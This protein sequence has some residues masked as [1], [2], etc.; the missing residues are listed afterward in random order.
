MG[1]V[2]VRVDEREIV[3]DARGSS[4]GA[5]TGESG[6]VAGRDDGDAGKGLD[7]F[8]CS[9]C[10]ATVVDHHH[11]EDDTFGGENIANGL[12]QPRRFAVCHGYDTYGGQSHETPP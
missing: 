6:V 2:R 4:G 9:G 12:F 5:A 3:T 10:G 1:Y 8:D 11:I 7:P